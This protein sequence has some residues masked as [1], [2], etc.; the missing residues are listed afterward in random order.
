MFLL[1]LWGT[2]SVRSG[3]LD[4]SEL[5]FELGKTLTREHSTLCWICLD[6]LLFE[7]LF[8]ALVDSPLAFLALVN[9]AIDKLYGSCHFL[10]RLKVE[11]C[12]AKIVVRC[13][14]N[15]DILHRRTRLTRIA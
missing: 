3:F 5:C 7:K 9:F 8:D 14:M 11:V 4:A 1:K 13:E 10:F 15:I 6:P 12:D 2:L